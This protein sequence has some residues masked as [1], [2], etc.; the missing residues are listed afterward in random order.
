MIRKGLC[1]GGAY[2]VCEMGQWGRIS[3][4]LLRVAVQEYL[5]TKELLVLMLFILLSHFSCMMSVRVSSGISHCC[6]E[7]KGSAAAM[8]V[9]GTEE[10]Q[11]L[12]CF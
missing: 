7:Q 9:V 11:S 12:C 4:L 5:T 8:C 1:R 3:D 10:Q 6:W 2:L